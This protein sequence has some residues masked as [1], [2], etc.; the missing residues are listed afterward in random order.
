MKITRRQ[1]RRLIAEAKFTPSRPL[2]RDAMQIAL[3]THPTQL[4]RTNLRN[5]SFYEEGKKE[6]F[7]LIETNADPRWGDV[8]PGEH[9]DNIVSSGTDFVGSIY[10]WSTSPDGKVDDPI[11][12]E[13]VQLMLEDLLDAG[14][15]TVNVDDLV[16]PTPEGH[17]WY[18]TV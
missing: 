17:S 6:L 7:N 18:W 3:G 12:R 13:H 9:I 8:N 5:H 2:D 11:T 4:E 14:Y 15:V 1:L 16:L 10:S